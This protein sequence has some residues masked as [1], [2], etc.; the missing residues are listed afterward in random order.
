MDARRFVWKNIVTR[1][2]VPYTLI[3]DNGL[4]FDSKVEEK[5]DKTKQRRGSVGHSEQKKGNKNKVEK[6][7]VGNEILAKLQKSKKW[8]ELIATFPKRCYRV[9]F[10]FS[11]CNLLAVFFNT[12]NDI[13][14]KRRYKPKKT[15]LKLYLLRHFQKCRYCFEL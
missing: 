8:G 13:F 9:F 10:F 2:G 6:K 12:Y 15:L 1:F 3:S 4:Q 14:L 5:K 7:S 11:F